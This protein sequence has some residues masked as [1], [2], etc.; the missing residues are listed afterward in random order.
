MENDKNIIYLKDFDIFQFNART[1]WQE[2]EIGRYFSSWIKYQIERFDL[3]ENIDFIIENNRENKEAVPIDGDGEGIV[4]PTNGENPP[5]NI[6]GRPEV[7]YFL[8]SKS[9][10]KIVIL[11]VVQSEK[12]DIF[13]DQ[14]IENDD[15]LSKFKDQ[16]ISQL[17][18]KSKLLI[19]SNADKDKLTLSKGVEQWIYRNKA[20]AGI[21]EID[22]KNRKL[23]C[24]LDRLFSEYRQNM[25]WFVRCDID[26]FE[27]KIRDM[28]FEIEE[29][30]K[31]EE[32]CDPNSS[33]YDNKKIYIKKIIK[34]V[35]GIE[36]DMN[37]VNV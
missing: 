4:S 7:N 27:Y 2:M 34:I 22:Q 36:I 1:I 11:S 29:I 12:R 5:E 17:Q 16:K 3:K 32:R 6:G 10:K 21:M 37:P 31:E 24:Y 30:E 15:K 18:Q 9:A 26:Y 19:E 13:I 28:G 25:E 20:G 35:H 23:K 33:V 8:T 14:L